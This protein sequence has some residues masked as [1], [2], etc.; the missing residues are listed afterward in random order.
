MKNHLT[1]LA[2]VLLVYPAAV[3]MADD[4]KPRTWVGTVRGQV[5][6]VDRDTI[7][8]E[9]ELDR[10]V[11]LSLGNGVQSE[12]IHIGDEI[13][14]RIIHKGKQ[15]YVR[16]IKRLTNSTPGGMDE[17]LEGEVLWIDRDTYLIEDIRGRPVRLT[18]DG[19]TW[20]DGNITVGDWIEAILDNVQVV[21][22][23]RVGKR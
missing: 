18:V 9:D 15:T 14:A 1:V 4:G 19:T 12:I 23:A 11:R 10:K 5:M 22:A 6:E 7:I 21:H 3:A 16:S 8:L 2:L 20:K 13:E 17:V